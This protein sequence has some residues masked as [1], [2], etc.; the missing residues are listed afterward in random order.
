[1]DLLLTLDGPGTLADRLYR[2]LAAA[3]RD[4]RL[5][6]GDALPPSRELAAQLGISRSTVTL[7]YERLTAE[8]YAD[9]RVGSGTYVSHDTTLFAPR[10]QPRSTA[11]SAD[12]SPAAAPAAYSFRLGIPDVNL[13]PL[14]AWR[15]HVNRELDTVAPLVDGHADSSGHAG[16]R[17][18]IAHH[19]GM[20]RAVTTDADGV[21]VTSGAQQA[22]SLL[23]RVL[24]HPGDIV[25]VEEP[26]YT[27]V[28]QAFQSA[29][30][31]VVSM[32]V[33]A[34]GADP[35]A[36]PASTRI[37]Y[38]TPSHQFPT[39]VVMSRPR[40]LQLLDWAAA[41]DALVI[42]DDYDSE[43]RFF[44]RPLEPLH[45][46]DA[47]AAGE[48]VVAYVGTFSKA[49]LPGLRV[50]YV[51]PPR[52]LLGPLRAERRLL[53]WHGDLVTQGALSR[54]LATGQFA[55][56]MRR[57]RRTYRARHAAL[58]E[59]LHSRADRL[60]LLPSSAGLHLCAEIPDAAPGTA[61]R[62]RDAA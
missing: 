19:L 55:A 8:G 14:T 11:A 30:A 35:S 49:L 20:A 61:G 1:M 53:D 58:A 47:S 46:L 51:I 60:T 28:R 7:V 52:H 33:D 56:H 10:V 32:P 21:F 15:R 54:L 44:D 48:G 59:G 41:H 37:V 17:A 24:I 13:F 34:E 38:V 16:L 43:Y 39:G 5:A 29:G 23:A 18:G 45:V 36:L 26:G 12:Q 62:V 3:I 22:I 42:E 25:A 4:R 6:G 50:G 57:A 31:Q 40:R 2:E 27:P 9:A